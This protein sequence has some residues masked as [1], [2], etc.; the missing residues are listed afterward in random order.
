MKVYQCWFIF[1]DTTCVV[2]GREGVG[3]FKDGFWITGNMKLTK[4]A[5]SQYWIPPSQLIRIEKG[6]MLCLKL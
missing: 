2:V 5:D 3:E 1:K 6:D 4:G